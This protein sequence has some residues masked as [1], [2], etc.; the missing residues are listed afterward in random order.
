MSSHA[1]TLKL[2]L[3]ATESR[4]V[5][6]PAV[7]RGLRLGVDAAL[8]ARC[9]AGEAGAF[10]VL[11]ERLGDHIYTLALS[12]CGDETTAADVT[13]D[14]FLKLL[15]RIGQFRADAEFS[16]W[17]YRVVKNTFLD[18]ARRRRPFASLDEADEIEEWP[19][20]RLDA[21]QEDAVRQ[22]E[23]TR[24]VRGALIELKPA[25]RLLLI[26]RYRAELSYEE[27]AKALDL[28]PGTVASRLARAHR[29]LARKLRHL[30]V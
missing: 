1:Q 3:A 20:L 18:H 7:R 28:S 13:Q 23:A 14:V 5:T 4:S 2:P 6:T 27:I 26:L 24:A 19:E 11:V 8:L 12:F 30:D 25:W 17:L 21:P 29:K 9:R 16:S 15:D 22:A 10:D